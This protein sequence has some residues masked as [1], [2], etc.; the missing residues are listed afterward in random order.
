MAASAHLRFYH[1]TLPERQ[2]GSGFNWLA[3]ITPTLWALSEGLS[4]HARWLLLS[5]FAFAGLLLAS[6]PVELPLVCLPYLARNIWVA[7]KGVQWLIAS[8][9]RQG[10]R[11]APSDSVTTPLTP[12]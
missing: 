7:R 11:Q 3:V 9:L 10:Y 2:V 8:L 5:E 12:R 4:W 6:R 1:P